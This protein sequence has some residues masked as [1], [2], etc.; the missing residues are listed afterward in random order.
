MILSH[1]LSIIITLPLTG[2]ATWF[3]L[4]R[5]GIESMVGFGSFVGALLIAINPVWNLLEDLHFLIH[6]DN[7]FFALNVL[8]WT[9]ITMNM[10]ATIVHAELYRRIKTWWWPE[11]AEPVLCEHR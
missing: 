11:S 4:R 2:L 8:T 5:H 10:A 3:V 1:W 6:D 7:L 9:G